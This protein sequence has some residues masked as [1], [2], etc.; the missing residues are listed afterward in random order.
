MTIHQALQY[1]A[2]ALAAVPD[3]KIDAAALLCHATGL[4]RIELLL[5]GGDALPDAQEAAYRALLERRAQREPLQ[6]MLGSQCF[7]GLEFCV[8]NRVL[9]P[10][11][12]TET[13]CELALQHISPTSAPKVLDVCTGSGAIAVVL[14]HERPKA[15]LTAIDLST[16]ALE[17]AAANARRNN[18]EIRFL[19]GDLFAPI[20]DERFDCVVS[21]PPYIRS[22][23]CVSLQPEV[24][25]E[26]RM[27]LDGGA[28]GLQFYRR[29][30][31]EAPLRPDG[32]LCMEIGDTQGAAIQG[33]LAADGRYDAIAIHQD[34]YGLDRVAIAHAA[35]FPT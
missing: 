10:R 9:I 16:D 1:G 3:P 8:D 7:Y 14:K 21:N 2:K 30:I 27:A 25:R 19:Q 12:E 24:L 32:W 31:A 34:L 11:S 23:D 28:D 18:V 29:I 20:A 17:V 6:Y 22:D 26:P 13:L 15:S 35:A 4:P 5:R 33:L